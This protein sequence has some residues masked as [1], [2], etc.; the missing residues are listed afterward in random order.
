VKRGEK[1]NS[2]KKPPMVLKK[3]GVEQIK[4][5]KLEG[6]SKP[7]NK[8]KEEKRFTTKQ[9]NLGKN[10]KVPE[11]DQLPAGKERKRE[12]QLNR[13][14]SR[15]EGVQTELE[16]PKKRRNGQWR[17]DQGPPLGLKERR[18]QQT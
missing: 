10:E 15:K 16:Q 18:D 9:F 12:H 14:P 5:V 11:S 7:Q 13:Q 2:G 6:K 3:R 17:K 1:G 4:L 8:E